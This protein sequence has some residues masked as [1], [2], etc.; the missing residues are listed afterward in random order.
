[1]RRPARLLGVGRA[2]GAVPGAEVVEVALAGRGPARCG[3]GQERVVRTRGAAPRAGLGDVAHARRRATRR[4]G[5]AGRMLTQVAHPVAGVGRA[6]VA[7]VGARRTVRLLRVARTV[8][9]GARA[10][11]GD[12]ALARRRAAG[13]GRRLEGVARTR[14]AAPGAGLGDVAAAARG[15]TAGGPR[16]GGVVDAERAPDGAVTEI[17]RADV[18]VVGARGAGWL[19]LVSRARAARTGTSFRQIALI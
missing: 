14:A 8:R 3:R 15:G 2:A 11:L 19:H 17:R 5:V 1:A 6:D 9:A 13:E 18:A 10:V 7:V 12:V 16:V 4:P